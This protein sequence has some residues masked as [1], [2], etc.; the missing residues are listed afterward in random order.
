MGILRIISL[1]ENQA[2][3]NPP[4]CCC[5]FV[6]VFFFL[7]G[8]LLCPSSGSKLAVKLRVMDNAAMAA[9]TLGGILGITAE[10]PLP[11]WPF[12]SP[13]FRSEETVSAWVVQFTYITYFKKQK[14]NLF[15]TVLESG[16]LRT[17]CLYH[18]V[19]ALFWAAD[20][21]LC[22]YIV[23]GAGKPCWGLLQAY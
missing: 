13:V 5:V 17:G 15:L 11:C 6:F 8:M 18:Q 12:L 14:R 3:R 2:S 22:L 1:Q 10:R 7:I 23:E 9:G 19:R 20:F 21:S 16:S 4:F